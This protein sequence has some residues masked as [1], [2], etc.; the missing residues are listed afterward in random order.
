M[1]LPYWQLETHGNAP[2]LVA[3]SGLAVTYT[4]LARLADR[5]SQHL[6]RQGRKSLVFIV[7]ENAIEC[8]SAY[9]GCLRSRHAALLLDGTIDRSA[10]AD[11]MEVYFPG[12]IWCREG[13][14]AIKG[15]P[16][17]RY[18]DYQLIRC[19]A[20]ETEPIHPE[21]A[22]LL[23]T[24]G[25]T[26][27]HKLVRL[28]YDNLAANA[29]SIIGYLPIDD[30]ECTITVLPMHY[31]YG[32]SVI[33]THLLAGARIVTTHASPVERRF[34]DLCRRDA[35]TSLVGV[36]YTYDIYRR[37]G[38][39]RALPPTV[40]YLTQAGGRLAPDRVKDCAATLSRLGIRF[41]VMYGQTE[42]TARMS[43]LP[44]DRVLEKPSSVGIPI[45]G[46]RF[47][48]S[49]GDRA[50]VQTAGVVGELV[51]DGPNVCLGYADTREDLA[52][53]D[54]NRG[55][56]L[57]GDLACFDEEGLLYIKGRLKRFIK[58]AGQRVA[59]DDIERMLGESGVEAV[60][61]GA[62]ERLYIAVRTNSDESAAAR[63]VTSR[64]RLHP[65]M[66]SVVTVADVPRNTSGKVQ[67]QALYEE[68]SRHA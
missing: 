19:T 56:L 14:E 4:E 18:G 53:G 16:V 41:Y 36:P 50:T 64:L 68:L 10:L 8:L 28:S 65:T 33:N 1:P 35:I 24:S 42:A 27:G 17:Y 22:L 44:P 5:F 49:A 29:A 21:L 39:E 54:E 34:W 52:K 32:L 37:I 9:L 40:R 57:T 15:Q 2:A 66:Y 61:C 12:F 11:L 67:Y 20:V 45:P 51:Y 46:G 23:P 3:E 13:A 7:C 48:I 58:L 59:L 6:D 26:G 30:T 62:D 63:F 43:Y 47:S 38:L 55:R 25:S 60:C 31:S